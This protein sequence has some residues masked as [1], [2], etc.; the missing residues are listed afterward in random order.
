MTLIRKWNDWASRWW[1]SPPRIDVVPF[2]QPVVLLEDWSD[3][4]LGAVNPRFAVGG[5]QGGPV[6][7]QAPTFLIQAR[8]FPLLIER[9][10]FT[11]T[12]GEIRFGAF[13][14]GAVIP[15][16]ASQLIAVPQPLY[17]TDVGA[18]NVST[19]QLRYGSDPTGFLSGNDAPSIATATDYA[20]EILVPPGASFMWQNSGASGGS[21]AC[22]YIMWRELIGA[23]QQLD[24]SL[25]RLYRG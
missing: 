11:F 24:S 21:S 9:V 17:G 5:I 13:G 15:N 23:E 3:A 22:Q 4:H 7:A 12:L 16:F 6:A 1:A 20:V 19:A 14:P 2:V 18:F 25:S 8:Q 10:R